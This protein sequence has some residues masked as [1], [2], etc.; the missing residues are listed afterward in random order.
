MSVF[1][2]DKDNIIRYQSIKWENG[3]W[4]NLYVDSASVYKVLLYVKSHLILQE[5]CEVAG[6]RKLPFIEEESVDCGGQ[7]TWEQTSAKQW[8]WTRNWG[9]LPPT[10]ALLPLHTAPECAHDYMQQTHNLTHSVIKHGKRYLWITGPYQNIT[11]QLPQIPLIK[12]G[13]PANVSRILQSL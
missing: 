8:C 9:H 2:K 3:M 13:K 12:T 4:N 1:S 6:Q 11:K 7:R 5:P 10:P